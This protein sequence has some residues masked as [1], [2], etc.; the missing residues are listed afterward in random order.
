MNASSELLVI[1]KEGQAPDTEG[2]Q[3]WYANPQIILLQVLLLKY[4]K[5][6]NINE[7]E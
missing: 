4:F 3:S 6:E 1:L 2:E 5:E 7:F